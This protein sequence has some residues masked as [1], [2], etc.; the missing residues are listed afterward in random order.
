MADSRTLKVAIVGCGT[1]GGATAEI[2]LRDRAAIATR[3]GVDIEVT[4]LVSRT[5]RHARTLG[6]PK[7]LFVHDVDTVLADPSIDV[8]CELMGG[9]ETAGAVIRRALAAGKHVVTANKAL[10]AHHGAELFALARSSGRVIG[11]E[12]SCGG[13]IPIVRALTDG[14]LANGID[15]LYGVLNGTSNFILSEMARDGSDYGDALSRA[16][17]GGFA[18]ADPTLDVSG[19][20]AAHKLA[21]L[22]ALGFG[23]NLDL[24]SIT[25]E[26]IAE[27]KSLDVRFAAELGYVIKPLAVAYRLDEGLTA[28]VGPAF[29]ATSHPLA[30]VNGPFNAVSVYGSVNGHTLY[31]GRGAGGEPTASAVIADL[32]A[33]ASG[34]LPATF[35]ATRYWPDL[36][37]HADRGKDARA[38]AAHAAADA[39]AAADAGVSAT[40]AGTAPGAGPVGA[41][42]GA[43]DQVLLPHIP[44]ERSMG[45][46][47]L[48]IM[49]IDQPGVL[50]AIASILG[51]HSIS[52]AS[53]RQHEQARNNELIPLVITTH[54]CREGDLV[55]ALAAL[56]AHPQT[57]EQVVWLPIVEEHPELIG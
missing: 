19:A 56:E 45:R 37:E 15:A 11:F 26:G 36:N 53:L 51:S 27:L 43:G 20:D 35:A 30:W 44:V 52:I 24:D 25:V 3:S 48:R 7:S 1:V 2:L 46:Y 38:E 40:G 23:R 39:D 18:E 34:T 17:S 14:L 21:L 16:Q 41:G 4:A 8:V 57:G 10:L 32:I 55:S 50:A 31:Y 6:L 33:L 9:I 13:G 12:A 47:Y 42:A 22:A 29:I 49:A 28:W 5:F 54:I